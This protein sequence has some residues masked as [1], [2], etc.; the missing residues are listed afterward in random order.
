MAALTVCAI[1][2]CGLGARAETV[3]AVVGPR[4]GPYAERTLEIETGARKAAARLNAEQA[5]DFAIETYDDGCD[6]A[7][8]AGVARALVAKST[9]LVLGHPCTS[10]ALAAAEIYGTSA[11]IFIA[12]TT[13]H[14]ALT[15]KRAGSSVFRLAG[16][17]GT[18]GTAA[19]M[20]LIR[21][22]PG[23]R[24]A[25]VHDRTRFAKAIAEQA[26]DTLKSAKAAFETAT[27]IGGDKE[28]DRLVAKIKAAD[29]VFYAGFP[30]EAGFILKALRR[31][32]SKAE[33]II[34]DT[35]ATEEFTRTFGDVAG[36]ATAL[37]PYLP[38][39]PG[40]AGNGSAQ[41]GDRVAYA[42]V[43]VFAQ[44]LKKSRASRRLMP[45]AESIASGAYESSIGLIR[46]DGAGQGNLPDYVASKWKGAQWAP[47]QQPLSAAPR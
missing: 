23:R 36:E 9:A 2:M 33:M 22:G 38:P 29:A 25:L 24:F 19:A 30:L 31:A 14:P 40:D 5:L 45:V 4:T 20:H 21:S 28:Y 3:I 7:K 6:D 39:A 18:Q 47:I 10:S 8:A 42:A 11:S 15:E 44:A 37:L 13:R 27:V 16:R 17:D 46:F 41:A 12:T 1:L 35:A 34:S 43:E 32:G 26:A